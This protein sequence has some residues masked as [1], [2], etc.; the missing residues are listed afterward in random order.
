MTRY[1]NVHLTSHS[2]I[3]IYLLPSP[4]HSPYHYHHKISNI[5]IP[6]IFHKIIPLD[7][8]SILQYKHPKIFTTARHNY[9]NDTD[10]CD[11]DTN[12]DKLNI[13]NIRHNSNYK[14]ND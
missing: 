8:S 7:R 10:A 4:N 13:R 6:Y 1:S 3:K 5:R 2:L 11:N 9:N 12:T 14:N